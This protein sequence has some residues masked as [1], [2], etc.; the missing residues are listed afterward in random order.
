MIAAIMV[1]AI[2]VALSSL[3]T[4]SENT[5]MQ[6]RPGN[7]P[8][9]LDPSKSIDERARDL[10]SRMTPEEKVA[11]MRHDAPAIERLKVPAY[12]WWNECLHGVARYG[13]ATVYPQAIGLAAT[14]DDDLVFR[15][16]SAIG[17]E[18]RAIYHAARRRGISA[19]YGGL[20]YWTPNINIFRDPRWGRGQETY[21]EDPFLT[22]RI[23]V[24]FV[25]GLQGDHPRYLKAA[26]CA[27][28]YAVH[29]G[30]EQDRHHF[31]AVANPKD[32]RETYLPAFEALVRA[33]VV[34]V[35][36]AYNRTNGEACCASPTLLTGILRD[37]WGFEGYLVSDC[38]AL[39]DFHQHHKVTANA[40]E[41]AAAAANH[42][43]DLNCGDVYQHLA[44]AVRQGR[45]DESTIDERVITLMKVRLR[46]GMFDPPEMNPYARTSPEVIDCPEHRALAREAATKSIV[47]LKNKNNVLP[48][49]TNTKAIYVTGPLATSVDALLGNYHGVN[50][51]MVTVLE[52]ITSKLAPG[53]SIEYR[54]GCML[55]RPD[56][57]QADW[58]LGPVGGVDAVIAVMGLSGLLEGEE[59]DA[60]ASAHKGDRLDLGLPEN[61]LAYLKKLR[62][63]TKGPLIVVLMGGSPIAIPEVHAFA[64]AVL[65]AW[66]P[67]EEGG[68]AVA[69]ILFGDAVPSGRL[70]I[71][72][73]TS[74]EQLPP[75]EDYALAGRTYRYMTSPPL[76]PFGFGLSYANF[77][78]SDLRVEPAA[79]RSGESARVR[80]TVRNAGAIAGEEVVQLYLKDNEASVAAPAASLR[81]FKRVA[82]SPGES[83]TVDFAIEP[84][85]LKIIDDEG[86]AVYEA[87]AFEVIVGGAAPI[88]RSVALG[89]SEPQRAT[90]ELK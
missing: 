29:S 43:I 58:A 70:P 40:V 64:D 46:L 59:G 30:P 27:K 22:S 87:G 38:W 90:L 84:D 56:V 41:S 2:A 73:P 51:K 49:S 42:T 5:P 14:F 66:Y 39:Q 68:T 15:I 83:K 31:D 32:L 7:S 12:N 82:L 3:P 8:T 71:T 57:N 34:G 79:V 21:G 11:Q 89:A 26:A 25:R 88:A 80:V 75:Y 72:F 6:T 9:Y 76:Y 1:P 37:E 33:G 17:D 10:V 24:A 67:G 60:L 61:Q 50:P 18:G 4:T 65:F 35:M 74:V 53:G 48:L 23:G 63:R 44:E 54:P 36:G 19:G 81:G 13:K 62:E 52:G 45:V 28:H 20:T 16:A 47:L 55:N 69:D 85:M 78:Y 77:A 86:R